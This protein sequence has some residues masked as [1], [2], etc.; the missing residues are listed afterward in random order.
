MWSSSFHFLQLKWCIYLSSL[1]WALRL[2]LIGGF[3]GQSANIKPGTVYGIA[4]TSFGKCVHYKVEQFFSSLCFV[5]MNC[6][7]CKWP[8]RMNWPLNHLSVSWKWRRWLC[9]LAIAWPH[10]T[11]TLNW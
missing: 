5:Q 7:C 11:H 2:V 1:P 4:R 3:L 9:Y 8:A 10:R 6:G